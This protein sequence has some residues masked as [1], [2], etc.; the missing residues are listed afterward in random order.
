MNTELTQL[1]NTLSALNH[2]QDATQVGS[3]LQRHLPSVLQNPNLLNGIDMTPDIHT[4]YDK[5]T[6]H[7]H[8]GKNPWSAQ[9]LVW[10][11]QA[12]TP[13]HNHKCFCTF[14]MYQ[15]TLS[16]DRYDAN[17]TYKYTIAYTTG[18]LASMTP[19]GNDVHRM[20]NTTDD[21]AISLHFYGINGKID[22]SIRTI[23]VD[24]DTHKVA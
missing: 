14:A 18:E 20:R 22:N 7:A 5:I 4:G 11:P 17:G 23:F 15:G 6:L 19:D 24:T 8:T 13:I 21:M 10:A 3:F 1:I 16:E 12:I 9:V 2:M